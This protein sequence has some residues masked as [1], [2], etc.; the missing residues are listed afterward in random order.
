MP[1]LKRRHFLQFAGST[2]AT[3]GLSQ[4]NI[5]QQGNRYAKVLAQNTPRKLALLVGINQYIDRDRV[6]LLNGCVND[7]ELQRSLLTYRF[8]FNPSDILTLTDSQATRDGILQAFDEH[9]VKQ[10]KP[11][12][13]VVFHF[14]GHGSRL[15]D[16]KPIH[17]DDLNSTIIPVDDSPLYQEGIVNDIMG[18]TLFL[19]M[20]AVKTENITVVLDSCYSGGGTRGN[21]RVRAGEGGS[22]LK[23]SEAELT[24]QEQWLSRLKIYR[25]DFEKMRGIG[26][27]KGVVI[28]AA[29]RDQEALDA[30]FDDFYAGAFTYLLTQ[31]LW[32]E[33]G[34]VESAIAN[35]TRDLKQLSVQVPLADI[36]PE[37]GYGKKP[38]YFLD[39]KTPPAEAAIANVRGNEVDLWLGG[40]E[41]DSLQAFEE[42]ATFTI[43]NSNGSSVGQVELRSRTGLTGTGTLVETR[44]A[45]PLQ[46]GSLLQ[47]SGRTIPTDLKLRIGID[48]SLENE[49]NTAKQGLAK[50]GRVEGVLFQT[51]SVP[52]QGEIQY[53]LSR[54]TGKDR[55]TFQ[56]KPELPGQGSIGLLSP[57]RDEIIPGS[58]GIPNEEVETAISRLE[59]K[60]KSLLAARI[61]KM[62]LN[63]NSSRLNLEVS[64][65]V[66]GQNKTLIGAAFTAR[67]TENYRPS[68]PNPSQGLAVGTAFQFRIKNN[69]SR[70]VYLSI[71]LVDPSGEIIVL[72]PNRWGAARDATRLEG[73]AELLI[74]NPEVDDFEF[75]TQAKGIGEVLIVASQNPLR[76]ALLTLQKLAE[77]QLQGRDRGPVVPTVEVM[78]DLLDDLSDSR[79]EGASL[80]VVRRRIRAAEMAALSITFEVV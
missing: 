62:T 41:R 8:G 21:F 42:G 14:S 52:Y 10:A 54:L 9:L 33:T 45:P 74:P 64:M 56:G 77:E 17:P 3:I 69:E 38:L 46:P 16:P 43:I 65:E 44:S 6:G 79:G 76:K 48:P 31:Y 15:L 49:A 39:R 71:L 57:S 67:G 37:S 55:Q 7:V 61:V 20:S 4:F 12:D 75:I 60:L 22:S 73:K 35:I 13:V 66:E 30:V 1:H 24:T 58:F 28:A 27:A 34:T 68:I 18:R 63:A 19:L 59:A 78:G 36:Q 26:V 32:Q 70:P 23:P 2:F 40:L 50:I 25:E 5:L 11:T 53:I 29:Q 80:V 72:F 47:E 51:G